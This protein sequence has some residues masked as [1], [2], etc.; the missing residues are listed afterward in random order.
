MPP[1]PQAGSKILPWKGSMISTISLTIEVGREELAAPLAL[2]HGE[3][4]EEV[5]VDQAEGVALDVVGERVERPQQLDRARCWG[6]CRTPW[7]ARP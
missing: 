6:A 7:A 3:V 1:E 5:F 4:A 2:G